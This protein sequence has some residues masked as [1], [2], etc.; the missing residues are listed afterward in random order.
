MTCEDS[1]DSGDEFKKEKG[2]KKRD[3]RGDD[4]NKNGHTFSLFSL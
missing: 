4:N 2:K 3:S 1:W